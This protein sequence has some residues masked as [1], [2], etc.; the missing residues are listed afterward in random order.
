MTNSVKQQIAGLN[1][2]LNS[3]Y[4]VLPLNAKSIIHGEDIE[5]EKNLQKPSHF[6]RYLSA[7]ADEWNSLAL[8][9]KMDMFDKCGDEFSKYIP[10]VEK[11]VSLN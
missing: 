10:E 1:V 9:E 11:A 8:Y 2:S 4:A 5:T 6:K 3:W 7:L